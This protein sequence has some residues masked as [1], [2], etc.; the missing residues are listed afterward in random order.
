MIMNDKQ[1]QNLIENANL[2]EN[3]EASCLSGTSY[4]ARLGSKMQIAKHSHAIVDIKNPHNINLED[5]QLQICPETGGQFFIIPANSF[6]LA[7]TIEKFNMPCNVIG[8]VFNK[9]TFARVG[10]NQPTTSLEAGWEGILTLEIHN[11]LPQPIKLWVGQSVCK[12]HFLQIETPN[13][14]Y[15][16]K[17]QNQSGLT[18]AK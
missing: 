15:N 7:H 12:I 8:F 1:I 17:Y 11:H 6:V 18:G 13:K 2:I 16:G 14:Q 10:N 4:D 5:L 3:W 9:S